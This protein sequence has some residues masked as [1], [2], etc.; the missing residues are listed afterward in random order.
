MEKD[1]DNETEAGKMQMFVGIGDLNPKTC[2]L[3]VW[4]W[5]RYFKRILLLLVGAKRPWGILKFRV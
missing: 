5:L 2:L 3:W 4:V 1:I